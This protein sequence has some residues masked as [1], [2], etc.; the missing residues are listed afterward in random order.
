MNKLLTMGLLGLTLLAA[1]TD[2]SGR[3]D[4]IRTGAMGAAAGGV[5]AG[6]GALMLRNDQSGYEVRH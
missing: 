1:C 3:V 4:P 5:A 2:G 6:L